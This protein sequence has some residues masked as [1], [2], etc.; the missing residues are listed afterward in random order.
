MA[1]ALGMTVVAEGVETDA[2]RDL[3]AA[4]GCDEGQGYLLAP[5]L[6]AAEI[7]ELFSAMRA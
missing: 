7:A 3:L 1:H 5:G 6:P 4:V 2:Q